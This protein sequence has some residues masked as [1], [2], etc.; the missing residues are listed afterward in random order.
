MAQTLEPD[1]FPIVQLRQRRWASVSGSATR[2]PAELCASHE[3]LDFVRDKPDLSLRV[4]QLRNAG[5]SWLRVQELLK[6]AQVR[7]VLEARS[8]W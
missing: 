5:M 4:I 8:T 6:A 1:A 3:V 2:G 7:D